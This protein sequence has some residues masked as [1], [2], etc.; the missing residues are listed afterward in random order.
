MSG[1]LFHGGVAGLNP[2]DR[3]LPRI[4][5]GMPLEGQGSFVLDHDHFV[6]LTTDETFARLFAAGAPGGGCGD[7]Y[8][9]EAENLGPDPDTQFEVCWIAPSAAVVRV[10][11][12]A[13]AEPPAP[14]R[15]SFWP[16]VLKELRAREPAP[17]R[18]QEPLAT[19]VSA[20]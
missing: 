14:Y 1:P 13:V 17:T 3:I 4:E 8:E 18:P 19:S 5:S 11:E 20:A 6:H 15:D 12:R 2:G 9:V 16:L 7:L 10:V